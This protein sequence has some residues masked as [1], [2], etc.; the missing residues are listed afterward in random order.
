MEILLGG[1]SE[2]DAM[3]YLTQEVSGDVADLIMTDRWKSSS[4]AV[5]SMLNSYAMICM[6]PTGH[7]RS[8][9]HIHQLLIDLCSWNTF[10]NCMDM[11]HT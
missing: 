6:T 8:Q 7:G 4:G 3:T 11:L 5:Q 10:I 9:E 1:S 2:H